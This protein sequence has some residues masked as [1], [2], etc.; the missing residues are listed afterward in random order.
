MQAT[1]QVRQFS[2]QLAVSFLASG[3]AL[4]QPCTAQWFGESIDLPGSSVPSKSVEETKV[5]RSDRQRAVNFARS[6]VIKMNGGLSVYRP[7][8]C[9]FSSEAK[10]CLMKSDSNGFLFVFKGGRPGWEQLGLRPTH[11]TKILVSPDGRSLVRLYY[12]RSY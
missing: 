7:E 5:L 8:G 3:I 4:A 9:M 12:N 11:K 2:W 1:R 6:A 10:G